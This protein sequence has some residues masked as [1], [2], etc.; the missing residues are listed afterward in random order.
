MYQREIIHN[1]VIDKSFKITNPTEKVLNF[2]PND[3]VHIRSEMSDNNCTKAVASQFN[4][5][6]CMPLEDKFNSK[7][8]ALQA[9]LVEKIYELKDEKNCYMITTKK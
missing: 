1:N 3:Y 9:Y 7:T 4:I 8:L 5:P 2:P 6:W